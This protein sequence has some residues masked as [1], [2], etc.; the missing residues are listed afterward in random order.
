LLVIHGPNLNLLGSREPA[1]Y[2]S[3]SLDAIDAVLTNLGTTLGAE[4]VCRQTNHEGTILDWLHE[5]RGT[6]DGVVINP[7]GYTHT[8]VAIR[9]AIAGVGTPCVEVHLSNIHAREEFRRQSR[10]A[11]VCVGVVTGFGPRSY[12]LGLRAL[13]DYL[14]APDYESTQ[15]ERPPR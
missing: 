7:G 13:I 1:V 2:G 14:K 12:S 6:F 3:V 9:D 4:V 8:S 11:P 5:T 15:P 10:I